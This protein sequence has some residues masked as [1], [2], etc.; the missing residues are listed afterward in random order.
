MKISLIL[1]SFNRSELLDYGF[2]SL[3]HQIIN[4]HLEIMVI[5]DYLPDYTETICNKWS[6]NFDIKY[7]FSGQRNLDGIIKSRVP[8]IAINIGV[9]QCSGD[10]IILSC[11]EILHIND[12]INHIIQPLLNDN[13]QVTIPKIMGFDDNQAVL[14]YLN[15]NRNLQILTSLILPLSTCHQITYGAKGEE[16]VKMPFLM[17]MYKEL[18]VEMGGYDEDYST[19]NAY[20]WDDN[21]FV[22]RLIQNKINFYKV[23]AEIIHLWHGGHNIDCK[24]HENN[25]RW[26]IGKEIFLRKR[27]IIKRNVNKEWGILE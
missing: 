1:P 22:D 18:F 7:I 15:N 23:P 11:P 10:I 12:T 13:S 3:S 16:A 17:G 9:K 20:C 26:C 8:A 6:S 25:P 4:Q 21:D 19:L 24:S 14:S 2:W 5:N 27:G